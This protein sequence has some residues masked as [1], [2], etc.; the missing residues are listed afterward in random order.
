MDYIKGLLFIMVAIWTWSSF[1]KKITRDN[2]SFS[3]NL[4]I[5]YVLYSACQAIIGFFTQVFGIDFFIYKW[6]MIVVVLAI[7]V[8][9][10]KT[11]LIKLKNK[12]A[13]RHC[14]T[15]FKQH[16]RSHKLLYILALVLCIMSVMNIVYMW[17]GNH[18][19]DGWYLMKVA[20]SP[21]MEGNYD[22]V[23]ATG[24][25]DNLALSRAVNT[26]ELDYAFWSDLL[27]IYPTVFC[28]VIMVYMNYFLI[29]NG[30]NYLAAKIGYD[31]KQKPAIFIIVILF[32]AILPETLANHAILQQQDAWHFNTAVWY[33]SGIVR[34]I[35]PILLMI[36]FLGDNRLQ[37][38]K[39]VFFGISS[40]ALMSK[41][42]QALPIIYLSAMAII[43]NFLIVY[44]RQKK[45]WAYCLLP[46][47][48]ILLLLIPLS[49]EDMAQNATQFFTTFLKTRMVMLSLIIVVIVPF[50]LK[51]KMMKQ[52]TFLFLTMLLLAMVP[53]LNSLFLT[54]STINFVIA[55][56]VTMFSFY[57]IILAGIYTGM[58]L[59]TYIRK[60][61]VVNGLFIGFGIMC[62]MVYS[63]SLVKNFD[64]R[65]TMSTLLHNPRIIPKTTITL[66]RTLD[67]ISKES[68]D[69]L[70]V[71]GP[72]WVSENG[73]HH[74]LATV[75]RIQAPDI[76]NL[77][78][79]ARYQTSVHDDP[80]SNFSLG[81]QQAFGAF[82]SE[83]EKEKHKDALRTL[84]ETY[85]INVIYVQDKATSDILEK[86]FS[87][88]LLDVISDTTT[89]YILGSPSLQ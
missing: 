48:L 83:P 75:V 28:R 42:S 32:F 53:Q 17:M 16:I 23:Y 2:H 66:S 38:K 11:D 18:E 46:G 86:D 60:K 68:S 33:G 58:L 4:L 69:K 67:D 81:D 22:V 87:F 3:K 15:S 27:G 73:Y 85:P 25:S 55:R 21:F 80:A 47:A 9:T 74:S 26:F 31:V 36:P 24:F 70:Y 43:I 40:I 76:I 5:G 41:A 10:F 19:D 49:S 45:K 44:G 30:F 59:H 34:C 7:L 50:I 84:L 88:Q 64:V 13:V 54:L 57:I 37:F 51:N 56:T 20:L 82:L 61:L 12:T 65:Q 89:Y 77:S 1:G 8:Y 39:V 62:I 6:M 14:L 63:I 79:N 71:L 78:A 72:G 52:L 35:S 29:V